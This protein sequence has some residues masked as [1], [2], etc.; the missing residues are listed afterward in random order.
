MLLATF[1]SVW[2]QGWD[3]SSFIIITSMYQSGA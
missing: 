3:G 1:I 2:L